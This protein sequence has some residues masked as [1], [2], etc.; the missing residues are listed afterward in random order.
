MLAKDLSLLVTFFC[1]TIFANLK[2]LRSIIVVNVVTICELNQ[3]VNRGSS[4]HVT[5]MH[6][7][8]GHLN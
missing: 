6:S 4:C 3:V 5:V 1:Y 8:L 2:E 7:R